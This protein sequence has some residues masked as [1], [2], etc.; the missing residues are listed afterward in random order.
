[1]EGSTAIKRDKIISEIGFN[2]HWPVTAQS[3][4]LFIM[5]TGVLA[6]TYLFI[7]A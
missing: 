4:H 5:G 7:L 6:A 3:I 2:Y 1:V